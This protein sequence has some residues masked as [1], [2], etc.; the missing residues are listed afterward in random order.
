MTEYFDKIKKLWP[1]DETPMMKIIRERDEMNE[2]KYDSSL[3]FDYEPTLRD[4]LWFTVASIACIVG[5]TLYT[6]AVLYILDW[7]DIISW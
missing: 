7:M 2:R 4:K 1:N 3:F 5:V 6:V